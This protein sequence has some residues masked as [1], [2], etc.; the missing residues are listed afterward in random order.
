M[1]L[2]RSWRRSLAVLAALLCA[3]LAW[4][5]IPR[6]ERSHGAPVIE[7]QALAAIE[8]HVSSSTEA[9]EARDAGACSP[10]PAAGPGG[11][12]AGVEVAGARVRL[13]R[14]DAG[15]VSLE[16]EGVSDARG[17]AQLAVAPG[18]YWV[19]V[20]APA[21]ARRSER[22]SIDAGSRTIELVL[23]SAEALSVSVR[24]ARGQ[25]IE[26]ATVLARDGD[27]LPHGARSSALG[28]ASLDHVGR[29]LD[30]IQVSA[31]GHDSARIIPTS[32]QVEVTLSAPAALEILVQ[33]AAGQ[34][35]AGAEVS[36]S[37]IDF[38]PPRQLRAGADG[39][40]LLEGLSRGTYDLRARLGQRVSGAVPSI[41]LERGQ[42]QRVAL[43]LGEGRFIG[44][45]VETGD[46][47]HPEP[48][49]GADV[50]LVEDGLSPF[51]LASR[52]A[53]DGSTELG[54]LPAGSA[55][56]ISVRAQG[57]MPESVQVPRQ[58]DAPVLVALLRG[59]HLSGR[60]V[61]PEGRAIEGARLEVVGNDAHERPIS[62]QSGALEAAGGMFDRSLGGG[63]P[64]V[65][66]GEL[67]VLSGPLPLPGMPPV[68]PA[69]TSAW[70][71]DLDGNYHLDDVPPG[72]VRLLV[73]HP[74][75]V[76]ASSE[77]LVLEPGAT[78]VVQIVLERGAT[79]SGRVLDGL[80]RPVAKA[81]V[82][83]LS[84]Q[85]TQISAL[86]DYDGAFTFRALPVHVDILVARPE[87]R[88]RFVLR[89]SLTLSPG[90]SR[91][92]EL[93]LPAERSAL[94]VVILDGDGLPLPGASVSLLSLDARVPLR[95]SAESDG[96]GE[97][98]VPEAVGIFASLR[99]QAPGH[100][101]F[102]TELDPVPP[103][104]TVRL[105]RGVS[106]RGRITQV[107][108]R[109]GVRGAT[110]A[111]LQGGERRSTVS[112][113]AGEYQLDGI[114]LGPAT[115]SVTHPEFSSETWE[116]TIEPS[117]RAGQAV[118]L[119]PIDLVESAT[120]SG[121][122]VDA[123]G[124]PVRGARVGVGLVPAFVPSG[125]KPV[126]FVETDASG[127]FELRGLAPGRV[128]LSAYAT[129]AGRGRLAD[130]VVAA[131]EPVTGL[132]IRLTQ[133]AEA[134]SSG[135]ANV[136]VTLGERH[137]GADLEVVIVNVA[138]QS[139]AERAGVRQGDVLWSIDDEVVLDMADARQALGGP[140]G[141]DVVLELDRDGATAFARVR[142]E[143]VR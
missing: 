115:L 73:H 119:E 71:S 134:V 112:D 99:V 91:A 72:R 25:P 108:G 22:I 90:V 75:F 118:D 84:H 21:R 13:F 53:A 67:G 36:V 48:V 3:S 4:L 132:R 141:S 41:I 104:L 45:R 137:S 77:T 131:N 113:D 58:S 40:A 138:A 128:T 70:V 50:T 122:V 74:D 102:E 130:V 92:I 117:A 133:H 52:T 37:G 85:A 5:A 34:P 6:A 80:G 49:A 96:R 11:A 86:T 93:T 20:D 55:A 23:P 98:S 123:R 24:D 54:P 129:G 83:A 35:V 32:R 46:S 126:G 29:R 38:W 103:R 116:V 139:E 1:P 33:D 18:L 68:G 109:S 65:P 56:V 82:D 100:R 43:S 44:V 64:V 106:V 2:G 107:R 88:Q 143:L 62:R 127:R 120:A 97:L 42:R 27:L 9:C 140:V 101:S 81:R 19:L 142:R 89:K 51:P 17:R 15:Q 87:S 95:A 111:L 63:L 59:G 69:P 76:E 12:T 28:L 14:S 39:V 124:E 79:L 135:P 26:G 136:A 47:E 61:D 7:P 66:M 114:G 110:V 125:S 94:G 10:S 121:N 8:L 60:V 78:V 31:P 16:T 30:G 57:F 105:E